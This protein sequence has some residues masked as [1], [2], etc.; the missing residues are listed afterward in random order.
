MIVMLV[1]S[2]VASRHLMRVGLLSGPALLPAP[3]G[4]AEAWA[5]WTQSVPGAVGANAPWLGWM[6][7]GSTLAFG[8]PDWWATLLVLGGPALAAWTAFGFLRP[9]IGHG[10][11]TPVLAILWGLQLPLLGAT[12]RGSLD[13]AVLAIVLPLLGSAVRWWTE[14]PTTGAESL[15]PPAAI[16][17]LVGI[18]VA[19]MPWA[20]LIAAGLAAFMFWHRRHL[21]GAL[22]VALGPLVLVAPW[23][24]RLVTDPGRLLVGVDPATRAAGTAPNGFEVLTGAAQFPGTPVL[25]G[26]L[27]VGLLL[28]VG[29]LGGMRATGIP[30][31]ARFPLLGCAVVLPVLA[32]LVTRFVVDAAGVGVRPDPTGWLLIGLFALLVLAGE[33]IGK[34]PERTVDDSPEDLAERAAVIRSRTVLGAIAAVAA[35]AGALWWIIGATAPLSRQTEVLPSYVTGVQQSDRATRTL[36]VD[37]RAGTAHFNVTAASYPQW[38]SGEAAILSTSEQATDDLWQA[39]QQFAQGQPSDDMAQRL[40]SLGIAHVWLRGASTEAVTNL[41]SAPQLGMAPADEETVVFTV[42]TQPSR[43]MLRVPG[44]ISDQPILESNVP[45]VP[46]GA[47]VLSEPADSDWHA[48]IDGVALSAT[49]SDDWRQACRPTAGA[50]RHYRLTPTSGRGLADGGAA[51]AAGASPQPQRSAG[52]RR[53]LSTQSDGTEG[54]V[55]NCRGL[56]DPAHL[57][58]NCRSRPTARPNPPAARPEVTPTRRPPSLGAPPGPPRSPVRVRRRDREIEEPLTPAGGPPPRCRPGRCQQ[59]VGHH[60]MPR[61]SGAALSLAIGALPAQSAP[62]AQTVPLVTAISRTCPVTDIET[63]TLTAISSEGEIR[64]RDRPDRVRFQASPVVLGDRT[65]PIVLAP[66]APQA[67]VVGGSLVHVDEQTWGVCRR[68]WP[69]SSATARWCRR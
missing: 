53:A 66:S 26:L 5:A 36:M 49:D 28:V 63:S 42:T 27:G 62:L 8:Q 16:A 14:A 17:L 32:V 57:T 61:R 22:L 47:I 12:G 3:A 20:W 64:L 50:A 33:G 6:A 23:L 35:A 31:R 21:T 68:P 38:G 67:S 46:D 1:A 44:S 52:P 40:A 4:L 60:G 9:I 29:V 15:R 11:W 55:I 69:T 18:L 10:W 19:A 45:A 34:R 51:G 59:P 39:A 25:L 41:S 48:E 65:L 2:L 13:I 58:R 24:P 30:D 56:P 7:L 37:L 54:A 43:A